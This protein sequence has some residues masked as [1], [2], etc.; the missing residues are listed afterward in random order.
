MN[1]QVGETPSQ[2]PA[3]TSSVH[4][5]VAIAG[6][7]AGASVGIVAIAF[8]FMHSITDS[9]MWA[10][11]AMAAAPSFMGLGIAYFMTTNR[12]KDSTSIGTHP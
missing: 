11:A 4:P 7:C 6:A 2:S 1:I 3:S 5:L 8:I 9:G 12:H 10:V